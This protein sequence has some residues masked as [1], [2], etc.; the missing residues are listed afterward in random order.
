MVLKGEMEPEPSELSYSDSSTLTATH[1]SS[2]TPWSSDSSNLAVND[3]FVSDCSTMTAMEP[4]LWNQSLAGNPGGTKHESRK[5]RSMLDTSVYS[6]ASTIQNTRAGV[7]I[8]SK[9]QSSLNSSISS[10]SSIIKRTR[11]G[12]LVSPPVSNT[13]VRKGMRNSFRDTSLAERSLVDQRLDLVR[14][15]AGTVSTPRETSRYNANTLQ[16]EGAGSSSRNTSRVRVVSMAERSLVDQRL[17]LVRSSAGTVSTPRETSRY[18]ANTLQLEGAGSSSRN[19]SRVRVVS[20]AERSLVDQRLDLV[21]SSAGT[22]STPRETSRYNANTL[23]LEGA[24]SSSRN[25][26]RVRVVSMAERSLVDQRLDLVRSSA[27]TVS[28]SRSRDHSPRRSP[29]DQRQKVVNSTPNR[30]QSQPIAEISF[31]DISVIRNDQDSNKFALEDMYERFNSTTI[32]FEESD[33]DED[34]EGEKPGDLGFDDTAPECVKQK[35]PNLRAINHN[36]RVQGKEYRKADGTVVPARS[37]KPACKHLKC[38]EQFDQPAREMILKRFLELTLSGQNQLLSSY[39]DI[40]VTRHP[41]VVNS[42]RLFTRQYY[43]PSNGGRAKVCKLMFEATFDIGDKKSRII[44]DKKLAGLGIAADDL[45]KNNTCHKKIPEEHINF[46]KTHINSF[47]AYKSHYSS[48]KT[49]KLYLSCDL[50]IAKMYNLYIQKCKKQGL[51]AVHYNSYRL[52]F[53]QFKL[54]FR[55]PKMDTCNTCDKL[56]IRLKLAA[57]ET[58]A[59]KVQHE[60]EE[61]QGKA[62]AAYAEKKKDVAAAKG[63]PEIRTASFDLQKCLATP[64]LLCGT[65]FYS[66]Q[67]WTLNLTIFSTCNGVNAAHCHMWDESLAKRG[68]Q[69]IASCLLMDLCSMDEQIKLVTFYSDRCGGQNL[70]YVVCSTFLHFVEQCRSEGRDITIR[71]KFMT[72]GHSHMECDSIHASIEK[73]KKKCAVS[74]ETPR[75]WAIFIGSINRKIPFNVIEMK[76]EEFRALKELKQVYKR[77]KKDSQGDKLCFKDICFF[78]FR[79]ASPGL[80]HFKYAFDEDQYRCFRMAQEGASMAT[81]GPIA[82]EPLPL[83]SEK[84]EDLQKLLPFVTNKAYYETLLKSIVPKKRGRKPHNS[85]IDDFDGDLNDSVLFEHE[86]EE[87]DADVE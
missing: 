58:E 73:A 60:R 5:R 8:S 38:N 40:D 35:Q 61:H 45:R 85:V 43:L 21:R 47:P 11:A 17:D 10:G 39:M 49:E 23:Q 69:E 87:D 26:S 56:A 13:S 72:S 24:G 77:P 44:A 41:Q 83:P 78:E 36:A 34:E 32:L 48:A 46:I 50:N 28:T 16:L 71:H 55:K 29:V 9:G 53:K 80:V 19:T 15:S 82:T 67:L 70:N 14:S 20:M 52:I 54:S 74:I 22:V 64:H 7:L 63:S 42:R 84:L 68:S 30:K 3:V 59:A 57:S 81:P 37:I 6:E 76:Q 65:A 62:S 75:D 1:G 25:T 2:L 31:G 4:S 27:G 79:S 86:Q 12:L 51:D 33:D 66:R 18:N